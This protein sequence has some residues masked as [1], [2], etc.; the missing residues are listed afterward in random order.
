[1][2]LVAEANGHV[3]F[4]LVGTILAAIFHWEITRFTKCSSTTSVHFRWEWSTPI[5]SVSF[6]AMSLITEAYRHVDLVFVR[7]ILAA[8]F[9]WE[10]TRFAECSSTTSVHIRWEWSAPIFSVSFMAMSL[11]TEAYR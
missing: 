7:T 10:I 1:M 8:I 2:S 5:F 11:I 3:D 4:V 6:M 9:H